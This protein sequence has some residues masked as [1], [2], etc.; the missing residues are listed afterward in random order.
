MFKFLKIDLSNRK[1]K[2]IKDEPATASLAARMR[3]WKEK[4]EHLEA[5]KEV[6]LRKLSKKNQQLSQQATRLSQYAKKSHAGQKLCK[7]MSE[8]ETLDPAELASVLSTAPRSEAFWRAIYFL[9]EKRKQLYTVD[10]TEGALTNTNEVIFKNGASHALRA[11]QEDIESLLNQ[12]AAL[13]NS[14]HSFEFQN[15]PE[16]SPRLSN[17]Q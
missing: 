6:L 5:E 1:K 11:F 12:S 4:C 7:A 10:L 2:P 16:L 13:G 9:M 14:S 15:S 17:A 8:N 3:N